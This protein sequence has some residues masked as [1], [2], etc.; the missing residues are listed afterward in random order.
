MSSSG[1]IRAYLQDKKLNPIEK[2]KAEK[3]GLEIGKEINHF[4]KI[5][6]EEITTRQ[7]FSTQNN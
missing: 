3:D 7:N 1:K 6:W 5:G 2:N 4:A